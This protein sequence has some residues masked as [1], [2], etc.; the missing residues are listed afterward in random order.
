MANLIAAIAAS[1]AALAS[2]VSVIFSAL[3]LRSTRKQTAILSRQFELAEARKESAVPRLTVAI[4]KYRPPDA[5]EMRGDITFMLRNAG[6][7]G[8]QVVSVHSMSGNTHSQSAIRSI[9]VY[10]GQTAEIVLNVLPPGSF[11]PPNLKPLFE[12][13]TR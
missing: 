8:F 5:D 13:E 3:A 9:E 11:N 2:G 6:A 12:I 1:L 4:L 7:V 10:P